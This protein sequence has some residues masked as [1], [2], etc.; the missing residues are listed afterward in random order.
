M[1]EKS[2]FD[3]LPT[4]VLRAIIDLLPGETKPLSR[5]SKRL[6]EV[7]LPSLFRH[8]KFHFSR[9]DFAKLESLSV[10]DVRY[11]VLCFT[12]VV[13]ELLKRGKYPHQWVAFVLMLPGNSS[14][15]PYFQSFQVRFPHPRQVRR[16]SDTICT[17]RGAQMNILRIWL[18][19]KLH[20]ASAKSSDALW[21]RVLTSRFCQVELAFRGTLNDENWP[22]L[23]PISSSI[24]VKEESY[25]HHVRVASGSI[26]SAINRGVAIHTVSLSGLGFPF[27][28]PRDYPDLGTLSESLG[29]LL[30]FVQV[31]RLAKAKFPLHLLSH[32]APH[33]H[34]LDLCN[35][36]VDQEALGAFL[37][38]HKKYIRSIGFHGAQILRGS[39]ILGSHSELSPSVLCDMLQVPTSMVRQTA[40][41]DCPRYQEEGWR[42]L[43]D[44]VRMQKTSAKR[45]YDEV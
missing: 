19:M 22:L 20:G 27:F 44:D 5:A 18:S 40:N 31:L 14:R 39:G 8:V 4:E 2:D 36:A 37:K 32:H 30:V 13:P 3:T 21:T 11:H 17:I 35:V 12:N 15:N 41:C 9:V 1:C 16:K 45:K 23:S 7:C 43:L 25:E 24:T 34:R 42:L 38:T 6:R 33:L 28:D 29:R 26:E 10:S